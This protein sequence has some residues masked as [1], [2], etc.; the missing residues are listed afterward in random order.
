M[1]P[2]P[3]W[4]SPRARRQADCVPGPG[5][6]AAGVGAGPRREQKL[7]RRARMRR[8]ARGLAAGLGS[9]LALGL[10]TAESA[11]QQKYRLREV[12][13]VGDQVTADEST[14]MQMK[15]TATVGGS[16]SPME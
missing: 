11:A 7:E 12:A 4:A 9:L 2:E 6:E 10:L 14:T 15:L 16:E 5:P 1:K 13:A 3:R 8:T